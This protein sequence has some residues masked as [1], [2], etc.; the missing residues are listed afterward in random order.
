MIIL[1]ILFKNKTKYS[2]EAY[3]KFLTFH[4]NK[5]K[6]SYTLYSALVMIA[7]FYCIS[8]QIIYHNLTLA[9][10]LCI[11]MSLFFLWR[12]LRPL[13]EVSRDY[14]SDTIQQQKSF[15]FT[16]YENYLVIRNNLHYESVKYLNLYR[17]FETS[18]FFYLYID[19]RHSYIVSKSG[20][21]KGSSSDFSNFIKKKYFWKYRNSC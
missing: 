19:K 12:Y 3:D 8:M 17:I 7:L 16:F 4:K 18:E 13:S 15:T 14:K 5:Y 2:E 20:F 6:F 10:T 1:K 11:A 21:F 9:I